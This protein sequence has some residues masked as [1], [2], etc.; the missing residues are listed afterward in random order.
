MKKIYTLLLAISFV[1]TASAVFTVN[2]PTV[3]N[4]GSPNNVI[5]FGGKTIN[6]LTTSQDFR[7]TVENVNLPQGWAVGFCTPAGCYGAGTVTATYPV[8]GNSEGSVLLECHTSANIGTGTFDVRFENLS[9][10]DPDIVVTYTATVYSYYTN[11]IPNDTNELTPNQ[12]EY[13]WMTTYNNVAQSLDMVLEITGE[14]NPN[15]WLLEACDPGNVCFS[16]IGNSADY[17]V[18]GNDFKNIKVTMTPDNL[19]GWASLT[20]R[21]YPTSDTTAYQEQIFWGYSDGTTGTS[22]MFTNNGEKRHPFM[23]RPIGTTGQCDIYFNSRVSGVM[24]VFTID[25]K[26]ENSISFQEQKSIYTIE[27]LSAGIH[28]AKLRLT[29]GRVHIRKFHL[30]K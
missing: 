2:Y 4:S 18:D 3:V 5:A 8:S 11:V 17:T 10:G 15:G 6:D 7:V 27:N 13:L 30:L 12:T 29:N 28:I 1:T 20:I 9:N 22:D 23:V 25:G 19:A 26:L 14:D 24:E 21:I 16:G